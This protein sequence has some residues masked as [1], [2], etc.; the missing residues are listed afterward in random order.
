MKNLLQTFILLSFFICVNINGQIKKHHFDY[1][2]QYSSTDELTSYYILFDSKTEDSPFLFLISDQESS[3]LSIDSLLSNPMNSFTNLIL[4]K[5]NITYNFP[6][7]IDASEWIINQPYFA[8]DNFKMASHSIISETETERQ[9]INLNEESSN[10]EITFKSIESIIGDNSSKINFKPLNKIM[11]E[12]INYTYDNRLLENLNPN[13]FLSAVHSHY[14]DYYVPSFKFFKLH[15]IN[16][17]F[18]TNDK[19]IDYTILNK[20]KDTSSNP[21]LNDLEEH[22]PYF[23]NEY[24]A[25]DINFYKEKYI[26]QIQTYYVENSCNAYITFG[27]ADKEQ[28]KKMFKKF[29]SNMLYK[30]S[31]DKDFTKKSLELLKKDIQSKFVQIDQIN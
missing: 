11:L 12:Y 1:A 24:A 14:E 10:N 30:Y 15:K 21:F 2:L 7:E 5:N 8:K 6:V 31:K 17:D 20:N 22:L 4:S 27:Y 3:Q 25:D 16:T 29:N 18:Y 9:Y 19:L 26:D 28:Y 13:Y 23:C